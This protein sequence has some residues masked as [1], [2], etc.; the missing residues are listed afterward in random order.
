MKTSI[1]SLCKSP[2]TYFVMIFPGAG[3]FVTL[4]LVE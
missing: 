2:K 4:F 1:E 3:N